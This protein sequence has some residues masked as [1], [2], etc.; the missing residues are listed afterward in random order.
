M[1]VYNNLA[2]DYISRNQSKNS[3]NT[4]HAL[5]HTNSNLCPK[6][7]KH[8]FSGHPISL[9]EAQRDQLYVCMAANVHRTFLM[10]LAIGSFCLHAW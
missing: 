4:L 5:I 1:H 8:L 6:V 7:L 3:E 9:N 2:L 10:L